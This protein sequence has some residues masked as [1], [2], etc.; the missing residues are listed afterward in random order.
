MKERQVLLLLEELA[1]NWYQKTG[2]KWWKKM[3]KIQVY[4]GEGKGKSLAAMGYAIKKISEGKQVIIVSFLKGKL[5]ENQEMIE[6]LEPELK[7]LT[8]ETGTKKYEELT[9]E[10]K[11]EQNSKIINALNYVRKV[12][13]TSE[14]DLLILDEVL[15]LVDNDVISESQL[16]ELLLY[17]SS[18]LEIMLTGRKLIQSVAQMAEHVN[19]IITYEKKEK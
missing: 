13:D 18:E 2:D 16:H 11:E 7:V 4:F 1:E 17:P 12:M 3:S 9:K 5:Y 19:E 8:F 10:E 6:R 15:G 14:C